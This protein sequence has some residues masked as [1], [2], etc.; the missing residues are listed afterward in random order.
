MTA[1]STSPLGCPRCGRP[2]D[3]AS[4]RTGVQECVLCRGV[5]EA[6][7]FEPPPADT[8][9]PRLAEAGPDGAQACAVHAA[10]AAV[11]N[12]D[13]CGVFACALCRIDVDGRVLCPA[14]FER[15]AEAGELPGLVRGYRDHYRA[16]ALLVVVGILVIFAGVVTGPASLY[17]GARA[18]AAARGRTGR[19]LW[20]AILFLVAVAETAGSV[21]IFVN[22]A[23]A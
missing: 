4:V 9:V 23:S 7:R 14:C 2:L 12:C 11:A 1:A 6:T 22:M 19:R 16:Q 13:R 3:H 20:I 17:F 5:F 15:L 8:A 18:W 10:N 21:A